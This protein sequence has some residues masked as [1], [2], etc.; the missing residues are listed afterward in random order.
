MRTFGV[1]LAV[2]IV[3]SGSAPTIPV[4]QVTRFSGLQP[5]AAF[6]RSV[7]DAASVQWLYNALVSLPFARHRWCPYGVGTRY[8]LT[9]SDTGRSILVANVESDGCREASV[10]GYGRRATNDS[11]WAI[12]AETLGLEAR[13]TDQLFPLPLPTTTRTGSRAP[14]LRDRFAPRRL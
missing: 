7:G 1:A 10:P 14:A 5:V 3:V 6:D 11:F 8:Q 4:L 9:F 12:F 2:L 13:N